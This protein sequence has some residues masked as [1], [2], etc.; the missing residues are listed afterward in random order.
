M[1]RFKNSSFAGSGS[2]GFCSSWVL[3]PKKGNR[4]EEVTCFNGE[5][6]V[7]LF[8]SRLIGLEEGDVDW[9]PDAMLSFSFSCIDSIASDVRSVRERTTPKL[10]DSD[11]PWNQ[12]AKTL[13]PSSN[14]DLE[15]F[16]GCEVLMS[17]SSKLVSEIRGL[18]RDCCEYN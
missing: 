17:I 2:S 7:N 12:F 10:T 13:P 15:P 9:S 4:F 18:D 11:R 16:S 8:C 5:G 6:G 3:D 1:S 14:F